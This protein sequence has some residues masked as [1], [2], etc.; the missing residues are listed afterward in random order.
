MRQKKSL[1]FEERYDEGIRTFC[2]GICGTIRTIDGGGDKRILEIYEEVDNE[3][4]SQPKEA[5]D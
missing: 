3:Q 2:G 4:G 5:K 1:V